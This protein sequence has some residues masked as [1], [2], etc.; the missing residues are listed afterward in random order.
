MFYTHNY[1]YC[2][3]AIDFLSVTNG[4]IVSVYIQN[5]SV[6]IQHIL[7]ICACSKVSVDIMGLRDSFV[8]ENI[9]QDKG[10]RILRER[11]QH[12]MQNAR[13]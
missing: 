6:T 4:S 7:K 13:L 11:T 12:F 9:D 2:N 10:V 5:K 8:S 1:N 3:M